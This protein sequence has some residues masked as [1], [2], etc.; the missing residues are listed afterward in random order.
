M[1]TSNDGNALEKSFCCP[2]A[3]RNKGIYES[4]KTGK[5]IYFDTMK[6]GKGVKLGVMTVCL[7]A[8]FLEETYA[9]LI[10]DESN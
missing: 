8:L 7:G 1:C 4:S 10:N 3:V 2:V 5:P 9:Y 6:G